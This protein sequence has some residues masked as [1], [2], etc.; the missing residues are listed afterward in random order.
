MK[1]VPSMVIIAML[2][3]ASIASAA[4]APV[5]PF[6]PV[7]FLLGNWSGEASGE[8]GKG[9]VERQYALALSDRFIEEQNTSTY[10]PRDGKPA[11]VHQHRSFLSFDKDRKQL[12]LRQFHEEGFVNHYAMNQEQSTATRLVFDSVAFENLPRDWKARES[13]EIVA[14]DEFIEIFELAPPGKPL[15]V[16][17]R[18]HF[19]RKVATAA[20]R[21]PPPTRPADGPLAPRWTVIKGA[22]KNAPADQDGDF[23]IGPEYVPAPELTVVAG[24]PM[25]TIKQFVMRSEDSRIY[26]KA[27]AREVFGTPDPDNYKTLIVATHEKHWERA[28]TVYIP[29]S[30]NKKKPLPFMVTHDGPKMGEP[31][32][33]LPRILDNLIAQKRVPAIAV[34]MI[35]NGGGDAQGHQRGLEYDTMS[36]RFAEF[37]QTEV[38]PAV[39]RNAQ[40]RLTTDPDGD[41][42]STRLNSSHS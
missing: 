40:I 30:Y 28:I 4:D 21:P 32:L 22:G 15:A 3:A 11:E 19:K 16:Y 26:P 6:Q 17:S 25:G 23:L 34:V 20:A 41:R 29:A 18:N 24:V 8:P 5:D 27:I 36:G 13:Y 1:H 42:K 7:R 38:L 9:T 14:A 10:E 33:S 12:M 2:V 31:D 35:Q 39:E 37:I